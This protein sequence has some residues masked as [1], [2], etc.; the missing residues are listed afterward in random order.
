[1]KI[2]EQGRW[3]R[4]P[5]R[6]LKFAKAVR[7]LNKMV[8]SIWTSSSLIFVV[9]IRSSKFVFPFNAS[10]L[11]FNSIQCFLYFLIN[12]FCL[13]IVDRT[14]TY[15][16]TWKAFQ[17]WLISI[18][19]VMNMKLIFKSLK[20]IVISH[21]SATT[22][23]NVLLTIIVIGSSNLPH[24]IVYISTPVH[25]PKPELTRRFCD[26]SFPCQPTATQ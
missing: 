24:C 22:Q 12:F 13:V 2:R 9:G 17:T 23:A 7:R 4:Y 11:Y 5:K 26:T 16:T 19:Q 6:F 10:F 14:I 18:K 25:S 15:Q 1:M 8:G 20:I 21:R 3:K